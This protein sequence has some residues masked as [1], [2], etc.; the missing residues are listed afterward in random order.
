MS[1]DQDQQLEQ[2][3]IFNPR[4]I[5]KGIM[6]FMVISITTMTA[7]F[8]YTNTGK[9]LEIWSKIDLKYILLALV[10]TALDILIGGWRNH[11]F[12]RE[13]YPGA[14]QWIA[15]KANLA[16]V[17]M[18][19]VTPSQSGGG[20]AQL[21]IFYKNGVK[22]ADGVTISFVNWISTLLFLPLSGLIAYNII[23]DN[24]PSG[25]IT[26]LAKFGFSVFTTLFV[27]VIVALIFPAAIGWLVKKL[28]YVLGSINNKWKEK[29]IKFGDK[30]SESMVDYRNKCTGL[31][32]RKPYLMVL[33]FLITVIL[34]LNK[35]LLGYVIICAFGVEADFWVIVAI[36]AIVYLLL[37]F[38]PS[39]GGSGIA[40]ISI[41]G[42]M[43]GIL[44]EDYLASF[45]LL[46][47]SFLVFIPAMIG[48]IVVLKEI[49]K[50]TNQTLP[51]LS[52]D[53]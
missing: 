48:A 31:L 23:S 17:F 44:S 19:A 1:D 20:I 42:L 53:A 6:Y 36:Q 21:Y 2:K 52:S 46:Q 25:F 30:A 49:N 39:P 10:I 35:Y 16:N 8:L 15:F 41:T 3:D 4:V 28:S 33:S 22:L 51:V 26:H 45:T 27:V 11:I 9:T 7:I 12:V 38:A 18:G 13:L 47:R 24:I 34:Y 40:E 37:Y 14:S 43:A 50:K 5:K 29:L 32:R